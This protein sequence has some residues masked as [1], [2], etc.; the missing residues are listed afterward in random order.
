MR[1]GDTQDPI[2]GVLDAALAPSEAGTAP[3]AFSIAA[4]SRRQSAI[5]VVGGIS[6]SP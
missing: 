1:P 4:V 5:A 3:Q 2:Q 6:A